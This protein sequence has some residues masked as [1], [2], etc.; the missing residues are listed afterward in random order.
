MTIGA[1]PTLNPEIILQGLSTTDP[2]LLVNEM[3]QTKQVQNQSA[4]IPSEIAKNQAIANSENV[5]AGIS[6]PGGFNL[7]NFSAQAEARIRSKGNSTASGQNSGYQ[8]GYTPVQPPVSVPATPAPAP[9]VDPNTGDPE[10]DNN[11]GTPITDNTNP[12]NLINNDNQ[13]SESLSG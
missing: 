10:V 3:N 13:Y 4:L 11:T 7:A 5:N 9:R 1:D 12:T 6:V 8:G 2:A